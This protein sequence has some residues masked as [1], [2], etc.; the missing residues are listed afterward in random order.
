MS[1]PDFTGNW[2][3]KLAGELQSQMLSFFSSYVNPLLDPKLHL[4]NRRFEILG[5]Q[6]PV[7]CIT[8]PP[9]SVPTVAIQGNR[10]P[11]PTRRNSQSLRGYN[12]WFELRCGLMLLDTLPPDSE[13]LPVET[14]ERVKNA[15][16]KGRLGGIQTGSMEE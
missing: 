11:L 3:D 8:A 5:F 7:G 2:D 4:N 9:R 6:T 13:S 16:R 1:V 14:D 12:L 15:W 10:L